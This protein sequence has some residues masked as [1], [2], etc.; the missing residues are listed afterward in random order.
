MGLQ[1]ASI[2]LQDA[3]DQERKLTDEGYAIEPTLTPSGTQMIY[4]VRTELSRGQSSGE[5]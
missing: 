5:L 4:I 2:W 1:R 3:H